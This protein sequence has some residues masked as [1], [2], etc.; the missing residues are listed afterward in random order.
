M[1]EQS[2]KRRQTSTERMNEAKRNK[3]LLQ[4]CR[5]RYPNRVIPVSGLPELHHMMYKD[6][7]IKRTVLS[8]QDPPTQRLAGTG[9]KGQ[10]KQS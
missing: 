7:F 3:P 9:T 8:L 1:H 5:D 10:G 4:T 2:E 6:G